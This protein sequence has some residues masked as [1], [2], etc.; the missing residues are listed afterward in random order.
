MLVEV[1]DHR[2]FVTGTGHRLFAST[3]D[4]RISQGAEVSFFESPTQA[5]RDTA[6]PVVISHDNDIVSGLRKEHLSRILAR[7]LCGIAPEHRKFRAETSILTLRQLVRSLRE[8]F[9]KAFGVR[10]KA[11]RQI[12]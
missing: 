1:F 6:R 10:K 12:C 7:S 3:P 2:Q 11:K 9:K 8:S 5:R 4:F